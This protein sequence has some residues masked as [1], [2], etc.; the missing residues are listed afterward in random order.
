MTRY[1]GPTTE[2]L[3]RRAYEHGGISTDFDW[4]LKLLSRCQRTAAGGLKLNRLFGRGNLTTIAQQPVYN[5][6]KA[7]AVEPIDVIAIKAGTTRLLQKA[8]SLEELSA[9]DPAWFRATGS[10]VEFWCP[11]GRELIFLYP[12]LT[13][14]DSLM[15][16]YTGMPDEYTTRVEHYNTA[17][18]LQDEAVDVALGLAELILLLRNRS[19]K[20]AETRATSLIKQFQKVKGLIDEP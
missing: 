3:L 2:Q 15:V 12:T 13:Y 16:V 1:V 18:P 8:S 7:L 17:M 5:I 10:R 4:A 9:Y 19:L 14:N 6:R 11:I 20:S